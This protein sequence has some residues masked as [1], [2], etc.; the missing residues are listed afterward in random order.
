MGVGTKTP[1]LIALLCLGLCW[2]RW[3]EAQAQAGTLPR[4][5]IWAEPGPV[6]SQGSL[7]TI[8]C[9]ATPQAEV[10]RLYKDG[11]FLKDTRAQQDSTHKAGFLIG[12]ANSINAGR[13]HCAYYVSFRISQASDPLTLVVTGLFPAPSLSAQPSPVVALGGTVS[14]TC[15]SGAVSGPAYLLKEGG[16]G[17]AHRQVSSY[18]N[19]T[20]TWQA[21]F[22]VGP[23]NST[24]G[25][26]YRCYSSSSINPHVW[27]LPSSP[28]EL[29]VTGALREPSLSAHPAS[30]LLS[31]KN[32]TLRCHCESS[33]ERFALTQDKGHTAPPQRL[34]GQRSP[35]FHLGPLY[36]FHRG[37]YRC[38]GGRQDS[39][40]WSAP[41]APLDVLVAGMFQKPWLQAQPG[42]SVPWG[43]AVALR[44]GSE[45]GLDT[46]LLHREGSDDPPQRLRVQGTATP[47]QVTF[48]LS[49]VTSAH[50]GTYRCYGSHSSDLYLW[51][52]PSDP[53]QLEVLAPQPQDH[54]VENLIRLGVAG[55]VL[56]LL[57][58][59]LLEAW[60]SARRTRGTAAGD[61]GRGQRSPAGPL[62]SS[63]ESAPGVPSP[64]GLQALCPHS[65]SA[66]GTMGVGTKTPALIALLCLD[67]T[68]LKETRAQQDSTHKAG[69]L[70]GSANIYSA[71]RYQCDYHVS[72]RI[73]QASDLLT[74]V[75][76]GLY[77]APSLSAQPSPVVALGGTVSLS[78]D[79]GA[80]SGP[81]YL[82]KEGG[83]SPAH[84]QESSYLHG[85]GI[86]QATFRV[87]PVN[88]THGGVYRCYSSSSTNPHVWS[89]PSSPLELQVTGALREPSLSAHPASLLLSGQSLTLRC[90]CESSCERFAL[91]QDKG[92]TAP[93]QRLVGQRSPD[94][95]LGPLYS[96]HGGRY[97][98]YGGRHDSSVWSA[99]SA[100][101][102]V[103]VAGMFQKPWLQAQPGPSVSWGT[104]VALRCGSEEGLDTF[105]L[106][107]EGSDDPPQRLRVQGTATPT[108]VTFTLSP[109]TSAH[110][111]TY[112]CY[113]SHSSDPYLWSHPSDPLRL[114]VS[115]LHRPL[116]I[117]LGVSVASFLLLCLFLLLLFI[118]IRKR[119][120][121]QRKSGAEPRHQ[122]L[123]K[124]SGPAAEAQESLYAAVM[125]TA[126]GETKLD[127][128]VAEGLQEVTYAQLSHKAPQQTATSP[129]PEEPSTYAALAV[130]QPGTVPG[131]QLG[132]PPPCGQSGR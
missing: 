112:R 38:Y 97:R 104:A 116:K 85:T 106:H 72:F 126:A 71:G 88:S 3:D 17:P 29:Q 40:V 53:L 107:R 32:L 36:I 93:P 1:A 68:F 28:L 43:A 70:I 94:F 16:A 49:P 121:R 92:H 128:Q 41:S 44:C 129:L 18:L 57:G 2:G 31:G 73:S 19:R 23:V 27:S 34:V 20:R 127:V 33:C 111:G 11:T 76:T 10:Y 87:G 96:S 35:D 26:I 74:L 99:P 130:H 6:V 81:A 80:V 123:P 108:Q 62:L 15:N 131:G 103:L 77:G 47:A 79:S 50:G 12:S 102:D 86:W 98:C 122:A 25:G 63:T 55:L 83:A 113:G 54:T 110:G 9:Q 61:P 8:W 91:T 56:L 52:H 118:F 75:V 84:R 14:L 132:C 39:S 24:H 30:L 109:V 105:L 51:S 89:L 95:N 48:T 100:P 114:E 117:L 90:H 125:P 5:S 7:V 64:L 101:L 13:Y 82:L 119:R 46:F 60:L 22:R 4:P 65:R 59:L 69:F 66:P 120:Q 37:R 124:S 21:T 115:G 58:L 78:C 67:G 42:P 45:E